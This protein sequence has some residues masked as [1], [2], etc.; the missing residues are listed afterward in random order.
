MMV[1]NY[2]LDPLMKETVEICSA[3]SAAKSSKFILPV[4]KRLELF[5]D[6]DASFLTVVYSSF[7]IYLALQKPIFSIRNIIHLFGYALR[8]S[9]FTKF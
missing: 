5:E 1:T 9:S 6:K 7:A 8:N 3:V 4:S 2:Q